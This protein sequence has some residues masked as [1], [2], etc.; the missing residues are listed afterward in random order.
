MPSRALEIL[1]T[2]EAFQ[3]L[4]MDALKPLARL[5]DRT[6]GPPKPGLVG[7]LT[8]TMTKPAKVREL[9][10]GLDTLSKAA[11][12][13][14]AAE[15]EGILDISRFQAKYG[16]SP[17]FGPLKEWS[18]HSVQP[19][20][21]AL[22]F[23]Q[24]YTRVLPHDLH[25]LLS[26][27]VPEPVALQASTTDEPPSTIRETW[28]SWDG[29]EMT[30]EEKEVRVRETARAAQRDL[31]AVLRLVDAGEV[32]VSDKTRRPTSATVKAVE[33]VLE[34]GD[35]YSEDD[36]D[37]EPYQPSHD[38]KIKGFA[39]PLIVQAAK[40]AELSGTRLR[41][42]TAGRKALALPVHEVLRSAWNCWLN[43]TLLDE[44]HRVSG[45]KGL[46]SKGK[47]GASALVSRRHAMLEALEE[48]PAGKW[49]ATEE[50]FRLLKVHGKD[51]EVVHNP[52]Q[53]YIG[54]RQYGSLGTWGRAYWE[55]VE[56]RYALALLFEYAAT[57]GLIDVAYTSP[58]GA[59]DDYTDRWGTDDLACLSRYD[60]LRYVRIN[61]LGAWC[62]D[63]ADS[64][65]P[66]PIVHEKVLKVLPNLDVVAKAKAVY[67]EDLILLDRFADKQSEA[68]WHLSTAKILKAAEEGQTIQELIE[69]LNAKTEEPVPQTVAI[70]LQDMENRTGKL[71]DVGT[72]RIIECADVATAQLLGNERRLRGM[73]ELAGER[74]LIFRPA[75]E[76]AVRRALRDLGYAIPLATEEAGR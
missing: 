73:C 46:Q 6:A 29:K 48:C 42:T 57:L 4:T 13:E 65:E 12:Q 54:E 43:S 10:D 44:F 7:L 34:G 18:S 16:Q 14:A 56:G 76:N 3:K 39:W 25:Q 28:Q 26:E 55:L 50:L 60:G 45:V 37:Q 9:Y 40:L 59:R 66:E 71:R 63:I 74:S 24:Q 21:L 53:L 70:F 2:Q 5:L 62:F 17:D 75:K 15:P 38:L 64:Y 30:G 58:Q 19:T 8:D 31:K 69:F 20:V 72:V 27:F 52:F 22:F 32:G 41:L 61:A 36:V 23:P 49:I 11:I 51:F 35:F 68:V 67:P 33:A 47:S 1:S